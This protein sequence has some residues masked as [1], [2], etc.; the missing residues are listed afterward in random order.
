MNTRHVWLL[1]KQG[2]TRS[3]LSVNGLLF[4]TIYSIVWFLVF[5]GLADGYG[6]Q[7]AR[8]EVGVYFNWI[9]DGDIFEPLFLERSPNLSY[10]FVLLLWLTPFFVIW[11]AG[12]QTAS[13]TANRYLRFL[14]P[15]CGRFEI[16]FG[17]FLG[18][19]LF[20]VLVQSV[21]VCV[22]VIIVSV[23]ESAL[24]WPYVVKIFLLL[25]IY[26]FAYCALMAML[27]A[28]IA[29]IGVAI[30]A[31]MTLHI[32]VMILSGL[33]G[34]QVAWAKFFDY[35]LPSN[36]NNEFLIAEGGQLVLSAGAVMAY[37][38]AYLAIGWLYFKSKD[39]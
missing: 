31:A 14:M 6:E 15:R 18:A 27:S 8:L 10:F 9:L 19:Y 30:L 5:K 13:D 25:A 35:I 23:G 11:C 34:K 1:A 21:V 16:F 26:T 24:S 3:A 22:A 28:V 32:A 33:V 17:R 38:L 39:V 7:I 2:F 4:L 20:A 36:F 12:D 37:A 29:S